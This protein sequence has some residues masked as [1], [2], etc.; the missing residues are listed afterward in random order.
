MQVG[1]N[2]SQNENTYTE[3]ILEVLLMS[4]VKCSVEYIS[5]FNGEGFEVEC[6]VATCSRCGYET[7]SWGAGESSVKRCL[8]LMNEE[9]P[10]EENN[11]YV[12]G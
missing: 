3:G 6:V 8:A 10:N 5:D 11:F 9:C 1:K 4:R 2:P 12:G 7:R